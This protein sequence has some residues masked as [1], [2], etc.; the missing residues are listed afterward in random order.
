MP[1]KPSRKPTTSSSTPAGFI[2]SPLLRTDWLRT[3][4]LWLSNRS[5]FE[6]FISS[7]PDVR[8]NILYDLAKL[9]LFQD[10][11]AQILRRYPSLHSLIKN[12]Q[13]RLCMLDSYMLL[14]IKLNRCEKAP[15]DMRLIMNT[16]SSIGRGVPDFQSRLVS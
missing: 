4:Q 1:G 2:I 8:A 5:G 11:F 12:E 14:S 6:F 13:D 16:K 9:A 10:N 7:L 3:R 15:R